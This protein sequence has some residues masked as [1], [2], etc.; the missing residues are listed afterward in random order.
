MEMKHVKKCM[1]NITIPVRSLTFILKPQ[2]IPTDPSR[3][4]FK[5]CVHFQVKCPLLFSDFNQNRNVT[6]DFANTSPYQI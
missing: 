3:V 2:L 1:H 4:T 6:K 5:I